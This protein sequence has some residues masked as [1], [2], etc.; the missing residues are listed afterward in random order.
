MRQAKVV[1]GAGF[2]DEGKGLVTDALAAP[3]GE[4]AIV[5][6]FNGG[7]QAGHTVT[8]AD[9]RR[10]VFHHVGSGAL[11][12]AATYLS[13]FFVCNPLVLEREWPLLVALGVAPSIFAD[14]LC[15]V[16]TP[17]DMM[18]NQLVEEQ[19]G[20]QRHGSCGLGFGETL[21]RQQDVQYALCLS[22]LSNQTQIMM[23]LHTIR[24]GWLPKRLAALGISTISAIWQKRL[25][26]D[27][28]LDFYCQSVDRFL[29]QVEMRDMTLLQENRPI[30]FEG[31]QGL[32]LDQD[33][34]WFPH[35]TRSNT[36]LRNVVILAREAGIEKLHV[37]Y[38]TRAYATRHG[39]GPLA[40]EVSKKP[41]VRIEDATN[42][43]NDFQ[44]ALRFGWLDIDLLAQFIQND[45]QTYGGGITIQ[46]CLGITCLDQVDEKVA[47]VRDGKLVQASRDEFV[48]I[49]IAK[50]GAQQ[51]LTSFGPTRKTLEVMQQESKRLCL[52][53]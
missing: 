15:P 48:Q 3:Y 47:F 26:D 23:K 34:G 11:A 5:V 32:M 8:L 17:Y 27:G 36:G 6:R 21:A 38:L 28:I 45:W 10:H 14:P 33:H 46:T 7:A 16:T 50:V 30:I 18:I 39:A 53:S 43:P 19:R 44:G 12:G 22:D 4:D 9:G 41:Y 25:Q 29:Q 31:A 24:D 37:H 20:G 35:V 42:I 51:G 40:H 1:I 52:A 13:R 49:L 2:G